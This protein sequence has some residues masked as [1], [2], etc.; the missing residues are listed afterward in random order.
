MSCPGNPAHAGLWRGSWLAAKACVLSPPAHVTVPTGPCR[1]EAGPGLSRAPDVFS[2]P[3]PFNSFGLPLPRR[4]SFYFPVLFGFKKLMLGGHLLQQ[5]EAAASH[6]ASH[7]G[8]PAS[9]PGSTSDSAS[10]CCT[11][12]KQRLMAQVLAV[13]EFLARPSPA[14]VG[15]SIWRVNQQMEDTPPR[16]P[17]SLS[18]SVSPSLP[19]K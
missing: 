5:V 14:L 1:R 10:C 16:L 12:G 8:V 13:I 4:L 6:A 19:H 7:S 2:T 3:V 18:V 17:I 9:R 15:V 11:P